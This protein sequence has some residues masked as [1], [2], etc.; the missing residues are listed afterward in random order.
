MKND[1]QEEQEMTMLLREVASQY[2]QN[3]L[4]IKTHYYKIYLLII[5]RKIAQKGQ[6]AKI[7][8]ENPSQN[9]FFVF[10][11]EWCTWVLSCE[12]IDWECRCSK[13]QL[14]SSISIKRPISPKQLYEK[15]KK[16]TWKISFKIP[17]ILLS[18]FPWNYFQKHK[19]TMKY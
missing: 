4:E 18:L 15:K 13:R 6:N 1:C 7:F 17:K 9:Q 19:H 3:I 5:A 11:F 8:P 14:H 2:W 16:I 10:A 12:R